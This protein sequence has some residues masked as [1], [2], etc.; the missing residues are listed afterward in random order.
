MLWSRH[1]TEAPR[2]SPIILAS[3]IVHAFGPTA[4]VKMMAKAARLLHSNDTSQDEELPNDGPGGAANEG[5]ERFRRT[6]LLGLRKR[7][8]GES[9][10]HEETVLKH[11]SDH[12]HTVDVLHNIKQWIEQA[13]AEIAANPKCDGGVSANDELDLTEVRGSRPLP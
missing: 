1:V 9:G 13:S 10:A 4:G 8:S 6:P 5:G 3:K 12:D 7:F 2:L 11:H